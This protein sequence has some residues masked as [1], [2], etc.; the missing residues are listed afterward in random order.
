[1]LQW[2]EW[3]SARLEKSEQWL[4]DGFNPDEPDVDAVSVT[5][6]AR[7]VTEYLVEKFNGKVD[8]FPGQSWGGMVMTEILLDSRI[9][10]HTAIADGF[11]ILE[12]P[13]FKFDITKRIVAGTIASFEF[14]LIFPIPIYGMAPYYCSLINCLKK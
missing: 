7:K 9:S 2:M 6:E 11:T 12:F 10:V 4:E 1:M 13:N 5:E 14:Y 3:Q 8:I